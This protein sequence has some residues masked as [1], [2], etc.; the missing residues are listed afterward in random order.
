MD[1]NLFLTEKKYSRYIYHLL[2]VVTVGIAIFIRLKYVFIE[3][4]WPDEA[5]YCWYAQRISNIPSLILSKEII[6]FHPPLFSSLLALGHIF[7]QSEMACR[8]VSLVINIAGIIAIYFLGIRI[9]SH[10]LG[11]FASAALAF[12]YLYLSQSTHILADGPMALFCMLFILFLS[13]IDA[14]SP[15]KYDI[16]VGLTGMSVI[17][18][19]WPGIIIVPIV[20]IYYFLVLPQTSL[21]KRFQKMLVPLA[22]LGSV[23][24]FMV[25][26]FSFLTGKMWPDFTV[27]KGVYFQKPFWY[28]ILKFHNIVIIPFIIPFFLIGLFM[29]S[30]EKDNRTKL[31]LIWFLVFFLSLSISKEKDLRYSLLILPGSLLIAGIGFEETLKKFLKIP[32]Q[33]LIAKIICILCILL[34]YWQTYPRTQRFLDGGAKQFTGF[35]ETGN[36]IEKQVGVH[37]RIIAGSPRIIRYYSGIN[38]QEYGGSITM[39]PETKKE[40]EEL[41]RSTEAPLIMEIDYW[42]RAQPKWIYPLSESRIKY[43]DG[44]GFKLQKTVS[45]TVENEDKDVVWIFSLK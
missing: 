18:I 44:L 45:R 1:P 37:T 4:M 21:L 19:K 10:F 7:F 11:L 28:Y 39:L 9:R 27:L 22:I 40:F 34:F 32:K 25:I 30:R 8:I 42:E 31:L 12:N 3:R 6:Q 15:R 20:A 33:I 14:T 24:L 16:Y 26:Y 29:I 36:W 2:F 17:L 35:K 43:L 41:V 23:T 13:K 38:F 5:L